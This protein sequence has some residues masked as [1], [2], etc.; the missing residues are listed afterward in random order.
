MA[1]GRAAEDAKRTEVV[2]AADQVE[3]VDPDGYRRL[4][5]RE[6]TNGECPGGR[7]PEGATPAAGRCR[8]AAE[9]WEGLWGGRAQGRDG[10][11]ARRE[12]CDVK[13]PGLMLDGG[14]AEVGEKRE[15]SRRLLDVN[16]VGKRREK[17]WLPW[18]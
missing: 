5:A 12:V 1:R 6:M 11:G 2:Q 17:L 10:R 16:L 3:V 18:T 13:S 7:K 15:D 14:W 9:G 4:R 8:G